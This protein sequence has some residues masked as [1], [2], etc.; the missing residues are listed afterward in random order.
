MKNKN[1]FFLTVIAKRG[2]SLTTQKS[3]FTS[4]LNLM[5]AKCAQ[6]NETMKSVR[7]MPEIKFVKPRFLLLNF[8][9]NE[10]FDD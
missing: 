5:A 3:D 6:S 4:I 7:D 8:D 2:F 10:L 9:F 1:Y